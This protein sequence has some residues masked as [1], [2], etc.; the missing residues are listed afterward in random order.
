MPT[1]PSGQKLAYDGTLEGPEFVRILLQM[2]MPIF[3]V[4]LHAAFGQ[5]CTS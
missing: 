1:G 3:A 4:V 2:G 5:I